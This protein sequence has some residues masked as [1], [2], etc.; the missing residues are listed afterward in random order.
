MMVLIVLVTFLQVVPSFQVVWIRLPLS[1]ESFRVSL[2]LYVVNVLTEVL[3]LL[4]LCYTI[5]VATLKV[6][7]GMCFYASN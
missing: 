6:F 1:K 3:V 5:E 4:V 2:V 7:Y